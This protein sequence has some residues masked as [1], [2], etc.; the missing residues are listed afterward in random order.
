MSPQALLWSALYLLLVSAPLLLLM[1][2]ATPG[3][4]L[5]WDFA[6]ALG[7][8]GIAIMGLQFALTA[9]FRRASAPFG[10]DIIYY[11]HRLVALAGAGLLLAHYGILRAGWPE[12]LGTLN[13]FTAPGYMTAGRVALLLFVIVI[14][15]SLWRKPLRIEYRRWRIAHALLATLAFLLAVIHIEGAG[16]Y[17]Q[18]PA[19]RWL[20]LG[21]TLFWLLLIVHVRVLRPWRIMQRPWRVAEV[22]PERGRAWTLIVEPV[23]HAGLRFH[24]GQF[25]WLTLGGSPYRFDEHPFSI[26]SSAERRDG[27]IEFTI[28]ALGDFTATIGMISPGTVAWVDGPYGI[29]TPDRHPQATGL[30]FIAGGIGISP[31]MSMLRSL[32]DRR[33]RRPLWLINADTR[34]D[35]VTFREELPQLAQ[36]LSLAMIP[37]IEQPPADWRGESGRINAELLTRTLPENYRELQYFLCGPKPMCVAVIAMLDRLGVPPTHI[38]YELFDMV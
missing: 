24:P 3:I 33:E 2:T 9:R 38:H 36:R 4:A 8:A 28:K 27:R 5:W 23:G 7:F 25:A 15:S 22:R 34:W 1:T 26:S 35:D 16:Y 17:S 14:V 18:S 31:I 6:L 29:F 12:A 19:V 37:V 32:A 11:F 20:W 30:V 10:I 21:Y 13:P